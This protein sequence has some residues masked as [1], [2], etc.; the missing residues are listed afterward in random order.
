MFIK[1]ICFMIFIPSACWSQTHFV[2]EIFKTNDVATSEAKEAFDQLIGARLNSK[3]K[4]QHRNSNHCGGN[5]IH[6]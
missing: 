2:G 3:K 4:I 1:D 6:H 5:D